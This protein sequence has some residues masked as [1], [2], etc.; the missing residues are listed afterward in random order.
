MNDG[1]I[2]WDGQSAYRCGAALLEPVQ[3]KCF[4]AFFAREVAAVDHDNGEPQ[5]KDQ[6]T[7]ALYGSFAHHE[8]V[9]NGVVCGR[10]GAPCAA[11]CTE[12]VKRGNSHDG[13]VLNADLASSCIT[14]SSAQYG[15][16]LGYPRLPAVPAPDA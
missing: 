14:L 5:H 16:E 4:C 7:G 11:F 1:R 13:V 12:G 3:R 9:C 6:L 2:R 15:V 8:G 10:Y